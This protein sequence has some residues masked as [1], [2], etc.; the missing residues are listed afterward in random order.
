MDVSYRIGLYHGSTRYG[1]LELDSLFVFGPADYLCEP[2]GVVT[3]DEV[4][5][6]AK[7]L[8]REPTIHA[9]VIGRFEWREE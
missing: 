3:D 7:R 8:R 5:K 9:G 1:E 2:E 6:I 4:G